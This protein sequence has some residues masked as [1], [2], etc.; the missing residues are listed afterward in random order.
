MQDGKIRRNV[1]RCCMTRHDI[2]PQPKGAESAA[3]STAT[4]A[5]PTASADGE[6]EPA[7]EE[8][9]DD[10]EKSGI[11]DGEKSGPESADAT[12]THR[13][14]TNGI[15]TNGVTANF[16]FFDRGTFWVLPL[17]YF[18]LPKSARAYLFPK[19]VKN[20]YFCSSPIS[21]DPICRQPIHAFARELP[22]ARKVARVSGTRQRSSEEQSAPPSARVPPPLWP[23]PRQ[24][25][26]L[27]P[28]GAKIC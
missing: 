13:K 27:D 14:G 7:V 16:K 8:A 28:P 20:H 26:G 23:P 11:D 18:Y 15:S 5:S 10:G 17:A 2:L 4:C 9:V 21:V 6:P 3:V 12:G 1:I 25:A 24:A 22:S 19:S